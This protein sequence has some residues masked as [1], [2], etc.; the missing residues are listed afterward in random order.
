M[1][2]SAKEIAKA[3]HFSEAAVSM[4]LNQK[5]GV[6]EKNR[7]VIID[8]AKASGY[9][10]SR[11]EEKNS[12]NGNLAFVVYKK[13]GTI[14][15]DTPFFQKLTSGIQMAAKRKGYALL[16]YFLTDSD[17]T[18]N[19]IKAIERMN[20]SGVILLGTEIQEI[21]LRLFVNAFPRL[22]VLDTYFE[23]INANYVLINNVQGAFNSVEYL[24][25]KYGSQPGYLKSS[26]AIN[27]FEERA[28]GFYKA[29]RGNG[30]SASKSIVHRLSPTIDGAYCDM[31]EILGNKDSLA[32]SYFA[33]ND[34]IALGAY[35]AFVEKGYRIPD[36]IAI[37][38][39]D[40]ISLPGFES[41]HLTTVNVEKESLGMAAVERL[42]QIIKSGEQGKVKIQIATNL[43]QRDS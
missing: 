34:L 4:A 35:K 39:F 25:K 28:D 22:V 13:N 2:I 20:V 11:I 30:L 27:N 19:E 43:I 17:N 15:D 10:F 5:K 23:S 41:I 3:L 1:S 29:I 38:G 32:R 7:K 14:V 31:M 21:A 12:F 42:F 40:N 6:S 9:D 36:D 8:F 16:T 24:I 18:A 37:I 33:D 26:Y